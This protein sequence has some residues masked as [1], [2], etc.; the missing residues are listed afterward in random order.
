MAITVLYKFTY[1]KTIKYDV[2]LHI[3]VQSWG[4]KSGGTY[5]EIGNFCINGVNGS[6]NEFIH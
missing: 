5:S 1:F 6:N 2:I 3:H 4:L